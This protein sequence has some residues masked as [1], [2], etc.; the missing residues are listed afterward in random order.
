[1][2]EEDIEEE[3]EKLKNMKRGMKKRKYTKRKERKPGTG[4]LSAVMMLSEPLAALIGLEEMPRTEV[5]FVQ[6]AFA[7]HGKLSRL[8]F[9]GH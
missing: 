4:G 7:G 5:I 2:T 1:M 8:P 6:S 9:D 3:R